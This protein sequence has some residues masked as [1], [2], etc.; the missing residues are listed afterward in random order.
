MLV[1]LQSEINLKILNMDER[2]KECINELLD[3]LKSKS[4]ISYK[5]YDEILRVIGALVHLTNCH[6]K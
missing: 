5:K 2:D 4:I 6:K 3:V 1:S